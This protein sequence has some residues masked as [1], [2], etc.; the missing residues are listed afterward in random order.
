M[1]LQPLILLLLSAACAPGPRAVQPAPAAT[2]S[3]NAQDHL[4]AEIAAAAKLLE[5]PAIQG[6]ARAE[7]MLRLAELY[8]EHGR[9]LYLEEMAAAWCC[10]EG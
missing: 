10:E 4:L 6:E 3:D 1:S 7:L 2:P 9:A 8:R 5:S